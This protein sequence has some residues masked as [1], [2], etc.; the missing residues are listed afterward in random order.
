MD[1]TTLI[2][3]A[4]ELV[5][6]GN[7]DQAL[8]MVDGF[9]ANKT[10]YAL[11][12][13]EFLHLASLYYMTKQDQAKR[14]ISFEN[15]ELNYGK[16]RDGLFNLLDLIEKDKLNPAGLLSAKPSWKQTILANKWL[17][18]IGA[19]LLVL[20]IAVLVLV[21]KLGGDE[22]SVDECL[23]EFPDT[24][25]KNFLIM[26]F[27]KPTGDNFQIEGLY[28]GRLKEFTATIESLK[29]SDFQQCDKYAPKVLLDF[30]E[31]SEIG[32]VNKATLVLWGLAEKGSDGT[33]F[34]KTRFKYLGGKDREGKVPFTKLSQNENLALQGEQAVST[35][36][37]LSI[38]ASSGEL[39]QGV[40]TTLKLMFGMIA[41]L[42]GDTDGAINAMNA[43]NIE[44]D[45]A[46]NLMKY[47]ILADNFIAKGEPEKAKAA[48]D[49]CLDVNKN[50]WLGRNNRANLRMESGDY[51]GAIE[52][53]T[54]ALKKQPE[55]AE[56]LMSRGWAYKQSQQLYAA[57]QD[58]EKVV[59]VKPE[60]E[61]KLRKTIEETNVEIKR[62][63]RIVEP[64]KVNN[65]T[66]QLTK[67]QY[68]TAA[69]AS[70]RLGDVATT[71]ILVTKGLEI[72]VN[73][74]NLIAIQADNL[75]KEKN[76]KKAKEIINA[77]IKRNVKKE[78][79]A[80]HSKN[81][82]VLIREMAL[83]KELVPAQ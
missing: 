80:K 82:A 43:A 32:A 79:I 63:E 59:K 15:A 19:P 34:V 65:E 67:Q 7:T 40:E 47:M 10:E 41:N 17:L 6:E 78:D 50:Y 20:S 38:I 25:A 3:K 26:P 72:D 76:T 13:K 14:T 5:A 68:I 62:L 36:K 12:H 4:K 29:N 45:S 9:L 81:V 1:K 55:D 39:T 57:K 49:T 37:V 60:V 30:N 58:F 11:L 73:N 42:E 66:R 52:D 61:P 8:D 33:T 77:A 75:I 28:T 24:T 2:A 56:M 54:V 83:N 70:N 53:L 23:V 51:I 64:T 71:R 16:V 35:D 18:F 22:K 21:K 46:A 48:L 27:Y 44:G 74:P 31:A 69:A